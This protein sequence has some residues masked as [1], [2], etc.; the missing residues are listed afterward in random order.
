MPLQDIQQLSDDDAASNPP[1]VASSSTASPNP[2]S[3]LERPK[4]SENV[5]GDTEGRPKKSPK[6]E[7]TAADPHPS[8]KTSSPPEEETAAKKPAAK[9]TGPVTKRPAASSTM[10]YKRPAS[11]MDSST[12]SGSKASKKYYDRGNYKAWGLVVDKSQVMSASWLL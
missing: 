7:K 2:S 12:A 1:R 5:E 9:K 4:D 8:P 11:S 6:V 3:A 10:T